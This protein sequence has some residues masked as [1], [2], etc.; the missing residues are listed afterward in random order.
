M[1]WDD[2]YFDFYRI[3]IETGDKVLLKKHH[4]D[5]F[6]LSNS[7]QYAVYYSKHDSAWFYIDIQKGKTIQLTNSKLF[8]D[9]HHD[10]PG[11][12][13][14]A[15]SA[16]W[17][18][19]EEHIILK[20]Q[21]DYWSISIQSLT[22]TRLT[23]GREN[24]TIYQYWKTNKKEEKYIDLE[25]E[26]YFKTRNEST[27]SEGIARLKNGSIKQLHLKNK[28]IFFLKKAKQSNAVLYREMSFIAYPDLQL[29]DLGFGHFN[30][31]TN[32]NPQQQKYNWGTVEL[33]SWKSYHNLDSLSGLLYKP[34][35]FDSTKSY[36]MIVYFYERN[37]QNY[38]RYYAPKPTA[39]IVYPTEYVSNGYLVFIPDVKYEI[40]KPAQG[41]YDCIVSGTRSLIQ[42]HRYIDSS[43]LGLQG[44]SRGG[45]QTA[46][47]I[48]MTS[49]YKCAMAGAPVS[50]MFSAYGGIRWGTGLNRAFQ[51]EKGQSR[52]GKT[53]WEAPDLYIENSPIFHLPKVTTP[54]LI[55][56]N[57]GDGAV[58]WYQGIELFN[59]LRRL[60]KPVWLL[61]YN[62]DEHN[63]KKRA[64][65]IDLSIRMKDFFDYYLQN[66]EAPNSV[67]NGRP[68]LVKNIDNNLN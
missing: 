2:W 57:D 37:T 64:N 31:L 10:V 36:P 51:Y 8:H 41:A 65:K 59:G 48:T 33:V 45:Y 34:E 68:A 23:F 9:Q 52:I 6:K 43:R 5:Q 7:G 56:H 15:G 4:N 42:S 61:N 60:Q 22:A 32:I 12:S 46:Q 26:L 63:L 66:N 16:F 1:T 18:K 30:R 40:G 25:Q 55:M 13:S 62:G 19:S 14:S 28:K 11:E 49:L 54:L 44:Q 3:D 38:H 20:G 67:L 21:Y 50:N 35:N 17:D 39:S 24:K 29:T 47:L 58:P 53:I 27:K